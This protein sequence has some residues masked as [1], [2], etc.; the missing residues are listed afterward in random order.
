MNAFVIT[1]THPQ[2]NVGQTVKVIFDEKHNPAFAIPD[3]EK[4]PIKIGKF[5][6]WLSENQHNYEE[7]NRVTEMNRK[8]NFLGVHL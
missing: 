7:R 1:R 5:D 6:V 4:T 8:Y 2:L 3:G